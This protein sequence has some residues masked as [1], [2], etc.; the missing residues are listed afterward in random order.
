[1]LSNDQRDSNSVVVRGGSPFS[2]LHTSAVAHAHACHALVSGLRAGTWPADVKPLVTKFASL[3]AQQCAAE[4]VFAAAKDR[5]AYLALPG[6][7]ARLQNQIFD[8]R[9]ALTTALSLS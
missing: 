8:A 3:Q 7:A 5:A 2:T 9:L 6:P 1:L 4:D